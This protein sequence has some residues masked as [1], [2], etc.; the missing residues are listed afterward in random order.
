MDFVFF[1]EKWQ[2]YITNRKAFYSNHLYGVMKDIVFVVANKTRFFYRTFQYDKG[3]S[4]A[5]EWIDFFDIL[6]NYK[7]KQLHLN[8]TED[9]FLWELEL[10]EWHIN[11]VYDKEKMLSFGTSLEE[12]FGLSKEEAKKLSDAFCEFHVWELVDNTY[13]FN[14]DFLSRWSYNTQRHFCISDKF[15]DF[16]QNIKFIDAREYASEK[17]PKQIYSEIDFSY[18]GK[19]IPSF[20]CEKKDGLP[21]FPFIGN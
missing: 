19:P 20:R 6:F 18:E 4:K 13:D 10:N 11:G 8:S 7:G 12:T 5:E 9:F 16:L 14:E 17:N 21:R 15:Y 2:E 3:R 1:N